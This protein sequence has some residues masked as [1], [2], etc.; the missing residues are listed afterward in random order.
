ME[1]KKSR[2]LSNLHLKE[3]YLI[4]SRLEQKTTIQKQNRAKKPENKATRSYTVDQT[5]SIY[6]RHVCER[7]DYLQS[8]E[9][10][11]A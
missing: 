11:A 5:D 1:E 7:I 3:L 8:L 6:Y 4:K 10:K 2:K 9:K